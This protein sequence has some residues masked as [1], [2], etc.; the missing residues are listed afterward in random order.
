MDLSEQGHFLANIVLGLFLQERNGDGR[1]RRF[2][3][4]SLLEE[5]DEREKRR[6]VSMVEKI[7]EGYYLS[8]EM[9]NPTR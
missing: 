3:L 6:Q 8:A 4:F 1:Q 9:G 5:N 7:S 2:V